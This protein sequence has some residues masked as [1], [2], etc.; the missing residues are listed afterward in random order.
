MCGSTNGSLG[1]VVRGL[2]RGFEGMPTYWLFTSKG[3]HRIKLRGAACGYI[4]C[5]KSAP[6]QHHCCRS[7]RRKIQRPN[8][9]EHRRD[10]PAP[11]SSRLSVK[12]WRITR[13]LPAPSASLI[14]VSRT[15]ES[16][17]ASDLLDATRAGW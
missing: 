3:N 7:K 6:Q 5:E 11:D 13:P 2:L 1:D 14:P 16:A 17:R 15:C 10:H 8:S 12:Y 9:V 4:D